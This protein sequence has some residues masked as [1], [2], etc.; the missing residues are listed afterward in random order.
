MD[1]RVNQIIPQKAG[2]ILSSSNMAQ[3]VGPLGL[4]SSESLA[5]LFRISASINS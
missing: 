5:C 2:Q 4:N 1:Y 3:M